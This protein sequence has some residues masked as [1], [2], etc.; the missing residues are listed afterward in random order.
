M[1]LQNVIEKLEAAGKIKPS[2]LRHVRS[3]INRYAK[4]LGCNSPAQCEEKQFALG[5]DEREQIIKEMMGDQASF[6]ALR[7][8]KNDISFLLNQAEK[9]GL[10]KK[11][12]DKPSRQSQKEKLR[13]RKLTS[14][15]PAKISADRT[16]FH[17]IHYGLPIENWETKLRDEYENW[18]KWVSGEAEKN[19]VKAF[20][21]PAT[22]E[23]KTQ[24][25]EA[26]FGYLKNIRQITD[27]D[28]EML[29][30]VESSSNTATEGSNFTH[31]RKEI[32]VGLLEEFMLWHLE[33]NNNA[34]SHQARVTLGVANSVVK[35]FY[36]AKARA[37]RRSWDASNY[38]QIVKELNR[39]RELLKKN[40]E[41]DRSTKKANYTQDELFQ[42]AKKEFPSSSALSPS[43]PGTI[44]ANRAG[45]ALAI[46]LLIYHPKL[47]NK[48]LREL[49]INSSILKNE[50]GQW[51]VKILPTEQKNNLGRKGKL[52]G[53]E[54]VLVPSITNFLE[55]Y[56]DQWHPQLIK[57]ID[58][59]QALVL[60]TSNT[61]VENETEK[62]LFLKSSGTSYDRTEFIA[63]IERGTYRWLGVRLNPDQIRK[64]L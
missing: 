9:L 20:N 42:A 29:F 51:I 60:P 53:F 52:K 21:E 63:W 1:N 47:R 23:T 57:R 18:K 3:S 34:I 35:N 6:Y 43:Q 27:L 5:K 44:L 11:I 16:G 46:M 45:R 14:N 13:R 8:A 24:K 15:L 48:N 58:Q 61:A 59:N 10:I 49:Q 54:S 19:G 55:K 41:P 12:S 36:L 33:R 40:Q 56:L 4:A 30:D 37:E 39:L 64:H 2:R 17:R 7:N 22:I 25:M 26:Y 50:K 31:L 28:F 38:L 32:N 62:Y